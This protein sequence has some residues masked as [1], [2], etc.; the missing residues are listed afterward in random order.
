MLA[1][2]TSTP[3]CGNLSQSRL[4]SCCMLLRALGGTFCHAGHVQH[5]VPSNDLHSPWVC[6]EQQPQ[7][8]LGEHLNDGGG[9][10]DGGGAVS[11]GSQG[12]LLVG[13][14]ELAVQQADLSTQ[15]GCPQHLYLA[16]C[17][18]QAGLACMTGH[19]TS[20]DLHCMM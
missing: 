1:S 20:V 5:A 2:G 4:T 8:E 12:A 19:G 17:R 7:Q 9:H 3:T 16:L 10:Q 15:V 18:L 11:K 6:R 14:L 13:P